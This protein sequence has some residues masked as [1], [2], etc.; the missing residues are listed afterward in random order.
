MSG[1][2]TRLLA[3]A[4]LVAATLALFAP[5]RHYDFVDYDDDAYVTANPHLAPSASALRRTLFEPYYDNWIPLTSLSLQLDHALF[6]LEPGGYHATNVVL[7]AAAAAA[8]YGALLAMTAAP[9]ASAFAAAVFAWHPQH[10]ES[11]AWVS[12]R[13]DVLSGLFFMLAIGAWAGYARRPGPARYALALAMVALGLLAKPMGV[14]LPFV[15]LLL[16][17]WPLGRLGD[18][19]APGRL[20]AVRVRRAIVEK[21]PMLP[22]ALAI[23]AITY[24]AQG[25]GGAMSTLDAIPLGVRIE[26]ALVSYVAYL[27]QAAWPTG[28]AVFYP[29]PS[30]PLPAWQWLGAGAAL[31]ALTAGALAARRRR[32]WLTV[33]WLW[34]LGTLVPMLGIVQVGMQSRA[35]RY[36]YVPQIGLSIA[37]AWE[38]RARVAGRPALRRAVALGAALALAGLAAATRV[39]L[40]YWRD[41]ETLFQ[42]ARE[43]TRDN[44]LAY[45]AIGRSRMKRGDLDG[46]FQFLG[47]ALRIQ[48]RSA[49][50]GTLGDAFAKQGKLDEAI[51][52]YAEAIRDRP[53]DVGLRA[54]YG[55]IL[56]QRGWIDEALQ[57]YAIAL[58]FD[59]RRHDGEHAAKI[60]L[61]MGQAWMARKR[62]DRAVDAFGKALAIDPELHEAR[63]DLALARLDSA[64]PREVVQGLEA[65]LAA[66]LDQPAVHFG[67]ASALDRLGRQ[68]QAIDHYRT[69]L[70]AQPDSSEAANN[71]AWLLATAPDPALRDA[72]EALRWAESATTAS[73]RQDPRMLDT[74]AVCLAAQGRF[75]EALAAIDAALALPAAGADADEL[76][77]HRA[78][79][80]ARR[81]YP[82]ATRR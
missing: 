63:A 2:R 56:V 16:D 27:R 33:G 1:D 61:L 25:K 72:S 34:Y 60:H 42:H 21:L 10:V 5:A 62:S 79:F 53:T 11:V 59:E 12:E 76:R 7:H 66:G 29:Y 47:E 22:L 28:L 73:G 64:D 36:M 30:E 74:L 48:P 17:F 55:Q 31:A 70:R 19:A 6:G 26:N 67:L 65:A 43:V 40:G 58:A 13:K 45:H 49:A 37:L 15:L 20:A 46:A 35:D 4:A 32:P 50:R 68:A 18:P 8:L 82:G 44:A 23:A 14:T 78:L 9:G 3:A 24:L 51:W 38:V 54:R 57:Q 71:L 75:D 81:P 41:T 77:A 80:A 39:Q 69:G 52:S